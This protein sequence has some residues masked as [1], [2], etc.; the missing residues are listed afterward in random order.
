MSSSYVT[1][2]FL[3]LVV[4]ASKRLEMK[5]VPCAV[6]VHA[7]LWMTFVVPSCAGWNCGAEA[8]TDPPGTTDSSLNAS[9]D[10]S[11]TGQI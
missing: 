4:A 11:L 1:S 7:C 8:R 6:E 9:V 10:S 3:L 5:H 2:S